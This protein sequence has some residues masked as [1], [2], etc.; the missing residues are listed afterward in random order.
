MVTELIFFSTLALWDFRDFRNS[1]SFCFTIGHVFVIRAVEHTVKLF[2]IE[3][4]ERKI[5]FRLLQ[6][7][8]FQRKQFI[9]PLR[10]FTGFVI[11]NAVCLNLL[12]RKIRCDMYRHFFQTEL[13]CRFEPRVTADDDHI[14]INNDWRTPAEF[15]DGIGN[16]LYCIIVEPGIFFIRTD[17]RNFHIDNLHKMP[18]IN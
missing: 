10:N 4:Q 6:F 1:I 15:T 11:R 2:R 5:K 18:F 12:R 9:V 14:L 17:I 13:F 16:S 7:P 8:E 3:P